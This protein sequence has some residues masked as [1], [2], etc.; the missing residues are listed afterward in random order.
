MI[1]EEILLE[2]RYRQKV[3]DQMKVLQIKEY[4]SEDISQDTFPLILQLSRSVFC[5]FIGL[6]GMTLN[7][8]LDVDC[9]EYSQPGNFYKGTRFRTRS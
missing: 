3:A 2:S 4:R 5:V 9:V 1:F 7:H 8:P 6:F